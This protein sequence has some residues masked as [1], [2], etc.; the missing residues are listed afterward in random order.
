MH[1]GEVGPLL[2]QHSFTTFELIAFGYVIA[3]NSLGL[4]FIPL[5]LRLKGKLVEP[6]FLFELEV[7]VQECRVGGMR[8]VGVLFLNLTVY[9]QQIDVQL[10]VRLAR[11]QH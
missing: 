3:E 4:T 10:E 9:L 11:H 7:I 1:D 6:L 2:D 5:F 8:Y